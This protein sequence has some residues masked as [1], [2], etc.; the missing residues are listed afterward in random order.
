MALEARL[1]QRQEQRL[2]LLPQMLQSIEVLQFATQDLLAFL[3]QEA[4]QNETLELRQQAPPEPEAPARER[5]RED[6]GWEEWRR[7]PAGDADDRQFLLDSI[8][9]TPQTLVD[10]V[11]QQLAFRAVPQVLA[12]AVVVLVQ[13]L[14]ERGLLPFPLAEI[15]ASQD[16]SVDLLADAHAILCSLEPRGIG[17]T[18]PV[19]AMLLQATGD[20]DLPCI[21]RLLRDHLEA[22]GRNKL[23]EVARAMELSLE[24]LSDLLERMRW[25][26]PRPA[27]AFTESAAAPLR[28][29]VYAWLRDGGVHVALDD[30]AVPE[31][32]VN[33]E[34]EAMAG[35]RGT[36]REVR[37]YL[38]PKLRNAR[39][40]I[41]AVRQRQETLQRVVSAVMR[42]QTAFLQKGRSA[43]R[44]LRMSEI[45]D[46]LGMHTSTVS[47]AIAGKHVQTDRGVFRLRDFFDG[48]RIDAAPTAGQGR[49]AVAQQIQDLVAAEDKRTPLS[50]DDLVTR[51]AERGVQAARRTVTKY[52]KQLG[53]PSSYLRRKFGGDA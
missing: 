45:A 43:I 4:Q 1:G 33:A 51:L 27:S 35:D 29:D 40:L 14:D 44:P 9:A 6:S 52:R 19:E 41:E 47:R 3:E 7:G 38:R 16:V 48:G 5:E 10:F 42:E 13:H 25:L 49:M 12:D 11:R 37:D 28:P 26:D 53:I 2:A 18:D 50:D 22:L 36:S 15:A 20:P 23:P 34:Y 46:R 39:D 30:A 24:D 8:A 32:A 31:L 21:E 17:A